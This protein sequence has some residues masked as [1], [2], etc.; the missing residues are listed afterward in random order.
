[1]TVGAAGVHLLDTSLRRG[2]RGGPFPLP[3]LPL[4]PGREVAGVVSALGPD[5]P[6]NWL[7]RRVVAH[8]G[9]AHGGYAEQAAA[10]VASLHE[11]PDHVS[12]ERAVAMIGTGRTA[13]GVLRI[14]APTADDVVLVTAAAG[15]LG[16]LFVQELK[17]LGATVVGVASTA[18]LDLVRE[19]GADHVVDYTAP[20]WDDEV[21]AEVGEVS[22]VLDGVGGDAGK[23]GLDLLGVGG[24]TVLFGW[25][26]GTPTPVGTADLYRLGI[27]ADV[28]VGPRIVKGTNLR[29]L[30]TLALDA[31]ASGRLTP[32]TT[33]FP[34]AD[35]GRAHTAL[36]NRET[37]GKVVLRP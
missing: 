6:D 10:N 28:A 31:L 33:A 35:A 34:L 29:E 9:Q 37:V 32:R 14:A 4:V 25:S 17:A 2:E 22:L 36:E 8:L 11:V 26:S 18:K 23:A 27:G 15:G 20:G 30:E 19:L 16:S 7:G 3:D 21:R 5:V 24:R 12:D 1:M 13:F